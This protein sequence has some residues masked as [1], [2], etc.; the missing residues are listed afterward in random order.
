MESIMAIK[1]VGESSERRLVHDDEAVPD[2][3]ASSTTQH[4]SSG[5]YSLL[6]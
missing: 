5:S 2:A 3:R 4:C 6:P 1:G